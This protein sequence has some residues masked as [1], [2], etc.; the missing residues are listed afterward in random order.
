M[1][2][3]GPILLALI[4]CLS[5]C[6][7]GGTDGAG[8][9]KDALE[10][11]DYL[12]ARDYAVAQL[13]ADPRDPI[14]LYDLARAQIALGEGGDA[15]ATLERLRRTGRVPQDMRLLVAEGALQTGDAERAL[16]LVGD[17][18]TAEG[19]RLRALALAQ[20]GRIAA[21]RKA[22]AAG[23]EAAGIRYRLF[24]AES[25]HWL[26]HGDLPRAA[27]LLET[28][29]QE[30]PDAIEVL[31]IGAQIAQLQEDFDRALD[32]YQAI[33]ETAPLD[34]P[35]LLGAIAILGQQGEIAEL[36]PLVERGITAM[37]GDVE[38]LY[39][40]ARL[41]A[42]QGDWIAVRRLMQSRE[43]VLRFHPDSRALY[44]R[45]LLELRQPEQARAHLVP[46]FRAYPQSAQIRR[47][48]AR[49]LIETGD[50]A[51]AREVLSPLLGANSVQP[52]D[53]VLARRAGIG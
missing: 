51:L 1:K 3:P 39:L 47:T 5:A 29:S 13:Q 32:N 17:P 23:H 26:D 12:S 33:L 10:A 14:A 16:E 45:A 38:F 44:A 6:A 53:R 2:G 48:Y 21:A 11:Q 35:A 18:V 19:W 28:A 20:L 15:L 30:A 27:K 40:S 36:R 46:L 34:R 37:P 31:Y 41:Y 4:A 9:A 50:A 43:G 49:A 52:Q 8:Q 7:G 25:R 22:F 24:V 42:E